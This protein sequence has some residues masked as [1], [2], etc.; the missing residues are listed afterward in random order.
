LLSIDESSRIVNLKSNSGELLYTEPTGLSTIFEIIGKAAVLDGIYG[1]ILG[2]KL[3]CDR[4]EVQEMLN[5]R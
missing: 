4:S 3:L 1:N 2:Y 5:G